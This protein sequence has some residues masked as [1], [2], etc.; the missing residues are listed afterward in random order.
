MHA[1]AGGPLRPRASPFVGVAGTHGSC[2][3]LRGQAR[4]SWVCPNP[5]RP[6]PPSGSA[7]FP[8]L[9]W[10]PQLGAPA[11]GCGHAF[12]PHFCHS[13]LH[14]C[15]PHSRPSRLLFCDPLVYQALG[16]ATGS[17]WGRK[18]RL[19]PAPCSPQHG[20]PA[21]SPCLKPALLASRRG[22]GS[23]HGRCATGGC[24]R[25]A[26]PPAVLKVW[27]LNQLAGWRFQ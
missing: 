14:R 3:G 5:Q 18:S 10:S 4:S 7:A 2:R 17:P 15:G 16:K 24:R 21:H 9:E 22:L 23:P 13:R 8:A 20:C 11:P 1:S 19:L 25:Q 12:T 27:L 6:P 26:C